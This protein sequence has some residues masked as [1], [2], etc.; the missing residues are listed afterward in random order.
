[1]ALRLI[2]VILPKGSGDDVESLLEEYPSCDRWFENLLGNKIK[3]KILMEAD[4]TEPLLDKLE[5]Q[6][7]GADCF[8][9]LIHSVEATIPRVEEPEKE[10]EEADDTERISRE[11][12][13]ASVKD[14]AK[15]S[16]AYVAMIMLSSVVA[17][18]G[19]LGNDVAVIIGAMV[20]APLLG[21]NVALSLATTLADGSLARKS[22]KANAVGISL[23]LTFSVFIGF[24]IPVDSTIPELASRTKVDLL[25]IVLALA[26]G[27]AAVLAFTSGLSTILVGVMVA[28]ALLPPIVSLGLLAGSG[29]WGPATGAMLLFLTNIICI[30][31]AGVLTFLLQGI[32]PISWWEAEKAKRETLKAIVVW[33]FLLITLVALILLS[34]GN[35]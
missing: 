31:L 15:V 18:I 32:K 21:P 7:S 30:N 9:I 24:L 26:S 28:V 16:K 4:K 1:M 25:H 13:Y 29:Q 19:I 20:I 10:D 6:F 27:I 23:A 11:E 5:N 17:S 33:V 8:R 35:I 2:E 14:T 12:L 34:S 22:L 3:V